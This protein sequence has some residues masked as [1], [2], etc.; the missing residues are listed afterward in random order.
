M[1]GLE[2]TTLLAFAGVV[3]FGGGNAIAVRQTV[4]ELPPLWAAAA[5]F[6][7]A[8]LIFLA[9]VVVARR[10]LPRGRSLSGAMLYGAVG[11]AASFGP[12][13]TGLRDVKGGTGSVLIA[14][15]PLLTFGLAIAQRQERFRMAGLL[16]ALIAL[17]GIAIVFAEEVGASVPLL[18]LGLILLGAV[19]IAESSIIAKAIPRSDPLATN[20]VAML[21]AGLL[22]LAGSFLARETQPL[23]VKSS[24]WIALGYLVAFGSVVMFALYLYTLERL[25]A[26]IVAY[27]TLLF[28]FV[29]LTV[30]TMLVGET[31]SPAFFL[32]GVV[33]LAG[34][35]VGAFNARRHRVAATSAPECLPGSAEP[36]VLPKAA[37]A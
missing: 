6:L 27:A 20:A 28:P 14:I 5:R 3:V 33:V 16:G 21:T 10:P 12:I 8:G 23:P 15:V 30:A 24:T 17:G 26:S 32:G 4:L 13:S 22:L 18:S 31:F 25:P 34:V 11:F 37:E 36:E 2:R 1:A 7:A 9:I 35:Y 29:G 19:A